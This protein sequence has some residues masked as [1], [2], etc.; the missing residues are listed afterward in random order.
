MIRRSLTKAVL[1]KLGEL[2]MGTLDAFF[3]PNYS[4]TAMWRPLLGLDAKRK[5]KVSRQTIATILWRLKCE[6]LVERTKGKK[7]GWLLTEKGKQL[8]DTSQEKL[9]MPRKDGMTRLVVFD[10]PEQER[11]KRDAIR[12]ELIAAR[13]T[14][15]QKS[16]WI[17][18]YPLPE[19]FIELIDELGL[20]QNVHILSVVAQGTLKKQLKQKTL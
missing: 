9:K 3:P 13:Y 2:G 18:A 16:V 17:G 20:E 12:A 15:L 14:Q 4:Y 10:I 7:S 8:C 6:G 19:D 5:R 1:V 11:K